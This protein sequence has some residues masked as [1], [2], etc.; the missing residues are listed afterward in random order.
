VNNQLLEFLRDIAQELSI[1]DEALSEDTLAALERSQ[2][3]LRGLY[4]RYEKPAPRGAEQV[5]EA[6]L[7]ALQ[8]YFDAIDVIFDVNEGAETELLRAAIEKAEEASDLLE[9]VEYLV[10]ESK[11]NLEQHQNR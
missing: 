3:T 4:E 1:S 8:L 6:M 5:R 7:E 10:Q 9:Q 2:E 11:Q